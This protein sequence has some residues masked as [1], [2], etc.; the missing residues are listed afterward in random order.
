MVPCPKNIPYISLIF[1][2]LAGNQ[3]MP[4]VEIYVSDDPG[5]TNIC[6]LYSGGRSP[7][8]IYCYAPNQGRYVTIANTKRGGLHICDVQ[9]NGTYIAFVVVVRYCVVE[10]RCCGNLYK[11]K[12]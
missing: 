7:N 11:R 4:Y 12:I 2:P 10:S 3:T 8:T 9:I 5:G 1:F 6:R